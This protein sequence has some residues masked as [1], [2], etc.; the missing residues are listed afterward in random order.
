MVFYVS[1]SNIYSFQYAYSN[2][3][4]EMCYLVQRIFVTNIIVTY[5]ALLMCLNNFLKGIKYHYYKVAK[6]T[7]NFLG[8]FS[9]DL[10]IYLFIPF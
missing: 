3:D 9:T 6:I 10:I 2:T 7:L 4:S 5:A 1:I 8:I